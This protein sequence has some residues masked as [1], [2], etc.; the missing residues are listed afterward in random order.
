[1]RVNYRNHRLPLSVT[2]VIIQSISLTGQCACKVGVAGVKCDACAP[3][4]FGLS[5]Q[6]CKGT[7]FWGY[8]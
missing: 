3:N 7:V 2:T 1:M 6:G 8:G 5:K 4:H